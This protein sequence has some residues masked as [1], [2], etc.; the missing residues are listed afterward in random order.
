MTQTAPTAS[1][2]DDHIAPRSGDPAERRPAIRVRGW[3]AG[4]PG[5]LEPGELPGLVAETP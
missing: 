3:V 2:A 1:Q 4:K 5:L